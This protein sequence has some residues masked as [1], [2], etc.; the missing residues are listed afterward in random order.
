MGQIYTGRPTRRE[1]AEIRRGAATAPSG[2]TIVA[3]ATPPG[4]S[5]L[6]VIRISGPDAARLLGVLTSQATAVNPVLSVSADTEEAAAP[7]AAESGAAPV[8]KP[9]PAQRVRHVTLRHKG[10]L[11]DDVVAVMWLRPHSPTGEDVAEISC[12]G[13][14]LIIKNIV[15]ALLELGA[16]AAE[17]G[18]FTQRAFLNGRMDLTQAEA[19]LDLIH[20]GTERAL[21]GARAMKEGRLGRRMQEMRTALIDLL[22]HLE[23]YID[24]PEEDIAPDTGDHFF[25]RIALAR[26]EIRSLLATAPLGRVLREGALIA[27]VGAP[28][29]GKSSL[30]NALLRENR[31]I[32]SPTPGTTRDYLESEC[33]IGGIA[34]RLVDTAGDRDTV[35][36]VEAEGVRRAREI[37]AKADVILHVVEAHLPADGQGGAAD[38][39]AAV[40]LSA[41]DFPHAKAYIRVANKADL[42]R[43]PSHEAAAAGDTGTTTLYISATSGEGLPALE[44]AIE[45]A[46]GAAKP[47]DDQGW[48]TV[49]ARQEAALA[50]ADAALQEAEA[51][52]REGAPPELVSVDL[53]GAL[54]AIGEVVGLATTEDILDRLFKNFCIGK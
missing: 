52:M 7:S 40:R 25:S 29:A 50:R 24:F 20:A 8:R 14:P 45:Q 5:A 54:H 44:S 16:R 19:V 51:A 49:N 12:H 10:R 3:L 2:D 22:A 18:E 27:I 35:D 38:G 28:N 41:A 4:V 43:H 31:A 11:L 37:A 46:L 48:L 1:A 30:L 13:N 53:R 36:P 6:A 17:P 42:G 23:A 26:S 21:T 33:N 39:G 34:V 15:T 9:W 32:I 47:D